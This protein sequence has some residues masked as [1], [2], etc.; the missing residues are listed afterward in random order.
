[1]PLS[2]FRMRSLSAANLVIFLLYAAILGFWVFLSLYMQG[3]LHY[4]ALHT[5]IAFVPMAAAGGGG[6]A[7]R[8]AAVPACVRARGGGGAPRPGGAP[9]G[10]PAAP[11]L[12]GG[13]LGAF[14]L[15]LSLV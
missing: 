15:G 9:A 6:A 1:M 13:L 12:P 4:S 11:V 7:R 2:V 3:T 10:P 14:G 8:G 5:G